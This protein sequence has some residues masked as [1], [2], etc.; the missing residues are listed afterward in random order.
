MQF[1]PHLCQDIIT[2]NILVDVSLNVFLY[3][4]LH[5]VVV[6]IVV[7]IGSTYPFSCAT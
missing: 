2:I 3:H 7:V 4:Y 5:L 6:A 1:F